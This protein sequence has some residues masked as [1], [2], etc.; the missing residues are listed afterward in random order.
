MLNAI[1]L[2]AKLSFDLWDKALLTAYYVHTRITFR[3]THASL[4][5][6]WKEEN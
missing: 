6:L 3:K 5:E 2:N 1:N 4:Y